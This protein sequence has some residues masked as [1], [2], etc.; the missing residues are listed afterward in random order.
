MGNI[1][2]EDPLSYHSQ[3]L[4]AFPLPTGEIPVDRKAQ[5]R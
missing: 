5:N 4:D 3:N 2:S 1:D